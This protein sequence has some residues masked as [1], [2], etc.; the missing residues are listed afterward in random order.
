MLPAIP[1][2]W[3]EKR[4]NRIARELESSLKNMLSN[5]KFKGDAILQKTYI[6]DFISKKRAENNREGD[7]V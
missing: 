1:L 7:C 6:V 5:E 4:S 3:L 2:D